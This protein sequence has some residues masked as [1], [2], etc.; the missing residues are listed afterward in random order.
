MTKPDTVIA[1]GYGRHF[2]SPDNHERARMEQCAAAIGSYHM[3]IFTWASDNC[4]EQ[5][6]NNGLVLHPTNSVSKLLMLWDAYAIARTLITNA[7]VAGQPLPLVTT[8]D[9]FETGV[10]GAL[11]KWR[12]GVYLT[13]QEH[14][15]VFSQ[16]YWRYESLGNR[17]RYQIGIRI[18]RYADTVRVVADR[19]RRTLRQLK[20]KTPITQLPVAIDVE[21]FRLTS[22]PMHDDSEVFTYLSVARFVAQ[23]N[24]PMLVRAFA[25]THKQY[26]NTRLVLVGQGPEEEVI[27]AEIATQFPPDQHSECPVTI[28]PW[29]DDVP[30]LMQAADAYVLSSN[31]EG[32]GR[33]LI[34]AMVAGLPVVTTDVGCVGEV[35]LDQ[36]HG[37][38]VPVGDQAALE[39]ALDRMV[40]DQALYNSIK[41]NLNTVDVR[42]IPGTN[43]DEYGRIL[44]QTLIGSAT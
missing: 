42:D 30:G 12:Y 15:D 4:T 29:S 34:E 24:L 25:A 36:I 13:V 38:V 20:V 11:L 28:E 40:S 33:V 1:I 10:I 39:Q 22:V 35:I 9:P 19:I 18:T 37:L 43:L 26:K 31:Y 6:G 8:Q 16:P 27:R 2:F 21:R 41:H 5:I 44:A 3:I 32:W 14:G 17:I 23:K 7:K